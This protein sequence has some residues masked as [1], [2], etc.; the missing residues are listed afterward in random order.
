MSDPTNLPRWAT[1]VYR[2]PQPPAKDRLTPVLF[3]TPCVRCA[4][5][6]E[7]GLTIKLGRPIQPGQVPPSRRWTCPCCDTENVVFLTPSD[8]PPGV[9]GW[10]NRPT[11]PSIRESDT[12]RFLEVTFKFQGILEAGLPMPG[13]NKQK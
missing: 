2:V 11:I 12:A 1:D 7:D 9:G 5:T 6:H 13:E 10:D 4:Y 3:L 8:F